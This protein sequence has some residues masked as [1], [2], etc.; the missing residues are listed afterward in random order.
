VRGDALVYG[1]AKVYGH[2]W[3]F[4]DAEVYGDAL[5]YG[6]ALVFGDARV[7]GNA[8]VYGGAKVFGNAEVYGDAEVC[9]KKAYTISTD[10]YHVTITDTHITIGCQ[11]H[12]IDFWKKAGIKAVEKLAGE[13]SAKKW[14]KYK[15]FIIALEEERNGKKC[16]YFLLDLIKGWKL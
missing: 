16:V 9:T 6:N 11:S 4:G 5:V 12:K 2:A 1:D 7:H 13:E 3:V 15:K 8:L 10:N 14:M